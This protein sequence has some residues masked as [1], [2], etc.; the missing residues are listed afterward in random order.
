MTTSISDSGV[1]FASGNI[2]N[3]ASAMPSS[4]SYTAGDIVLE[5]TTAARISGWKRLTTGSNHVLGTDW[6]YFA[7]VTAGTAVATTSGT[8]IDFTSIPSWV[9]RI[10]VMINGVSTNGTSILVVRP[11]TSGGIQ[12]SSYN[13]GVTNVSGASPS[14][15]NQ[16]SGFPIN[17]GQDAAILISGQMTLTNI[18]SNIWIASGSFGRSDSNITSFM[19]GNVTLSGTLDRL[20]LTTVNGTDTFDSGSVNILWE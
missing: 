14:S 9:K 7:G 18:S 20:R 12:S 17:A 4:G 19:G 1:Q 10:T 11:G 8:A 13:T 2:V 15:S 6:S 5:N 3:V 16:T